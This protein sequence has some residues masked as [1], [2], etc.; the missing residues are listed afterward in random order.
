MSLEI[1]NSRCR[2]SAGWAARSQLHVCLADSVEGCRNGGECCDPPQSTGRSA[3]FGFASHAVVAA[4]GAPI[5]F[6]VLGASVN[7]PLQLLQLCGA[8]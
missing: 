8:T 2:G 6:T 4:I 3:D 5:W 7:L 1:D